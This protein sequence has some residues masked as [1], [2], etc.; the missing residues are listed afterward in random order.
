MKLENLAIIN[1]SNPVHLERESDFYVDYRGGLKTYFNGSKMVKKSVS[2]HSIPAAFETEFF[3]YKHEGWQGIFK[4]DHVMVMVKDDLSTL[5]PLISKLKTMGKVVGIMF[6]ENG[7]YFSNSAQNLNWLLE[8]KKLVNKGDYFWNLNVCL[9]DFFDQI[10][11]VPVFSSWHAVPY[12]WDHG[13]TVP[14]EDRKGI[15]IGTRTLSQHLRRNTLY[16]IGIANKVAEKYNEHVTYFSEDPVPLDSLAD[17]FSTLGLH[18]V[19]VVKGPR[20]YE[21]WLQ[22]IAPHRLLFHADASETLGQ[23]VGDAMMLDVP[24]F[25]STT[26]NNYLQYNQSDLKHSA[27][28]LATMFEELIISKEKLYDTRHIK[29]RRSFKEKTSFE[30][31]RKHHEENLFPC[32]IR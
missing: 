3:V 15:I 14:R 9:E 24:S 20:T 27:I 18:K 13:F 11:D 7:N 12:E 29:S 22:I 5:F 28:R 16:A 10:L 19:N 30:G 1:C 26:T 21:E 8:F 17:V 6:H 23:V 4:Y 2:W 32:L 31:L 25:G